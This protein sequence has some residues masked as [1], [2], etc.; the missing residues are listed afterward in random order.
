M[1]RRVWSVAILL[2]VLALAA[3]ASVG[4]AGSDSHSD[5]A[6]VV[7][8]GDVFVTRGETVDGVFLINGNTR[9]AG[10]A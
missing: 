7:I 6:I 2:A 4:A 10:V 9:I 8:S 5:D 1:P 3:P